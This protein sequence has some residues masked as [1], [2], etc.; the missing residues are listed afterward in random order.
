M[1]KQQS[2]IMALSL[3]LWY[4]MMTIAAQELPTRAGPF[5]GERQKGRKK[6][7]QISTGDGKGDVEIHCLPPPRTLI[8]DFTLTH[9]RF[10]KSQMSS[11]GQLTYTRRTDGTPEP[12]GTLRTVV[13]TKNRHCRQL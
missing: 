8:L 3:L 4:M 9:T 12:D 2:V 7:L 10:G 13:R 11:L 5:L 6:K 1:K